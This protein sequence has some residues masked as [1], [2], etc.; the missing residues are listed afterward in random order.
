C[1]E[2]AEPA[3]AG[4]V[5]PRRGIRVSLAEAR[6]LF[7]LIGRPLHEIQNALRWSTFRRRHQVEARRHH[8][9]RRMRIQ[10]MQI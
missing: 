4:R 3:P 10:M 7:N 8:F 1:P 6:R 2:P 5:R 9:R